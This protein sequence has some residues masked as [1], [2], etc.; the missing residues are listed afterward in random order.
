MDILL[1]FHIS[2]CSPYFSEE[3]RIIR[4]MKMLLHVN[5]FSRPLNKHVINRS[6]FHGF[7]KVMSVDFDE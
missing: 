5:N 7:Q 1:F 6:N 4:H 3:R 2:K